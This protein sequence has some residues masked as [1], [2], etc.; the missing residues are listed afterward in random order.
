MTNQTKK[1]RPRYAI[2]THPVAIIRCVCGRENRLGLPLDCT[3]I[4][5]QRCGR[6]IEVVR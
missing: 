6:E 3:A 2:Y 4:A 5:C 1:P